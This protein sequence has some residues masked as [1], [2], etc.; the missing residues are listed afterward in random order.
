MTYPDTSREIFDSL[1]EASSLWLSKTCQ[2]DLK[3]VKTWSLANGKITALCFRTKDNPKAGL[4]I[5][6]REDKNETTYRV[7]LNI[8]PKNPRVPDGSFAVLLSRQE[9]FG[10]IGGVIELFPTVKIDDDIEKFKYNMKEVAQKHG[11][12]YE[13]CSKGLVGAFRLKD[14]EKNLGAEAGFNF[15][16]SDMDA[17]FQNIM[18][19]KE[20]Y[21]KA[22]EIYKSIMLE[23]MHQYE[24]EDPPEK[25]PF[26]QKHLQY[27]KNEDVGIKLALEQGI[28]MDFFK[29]STF[30]P[31]KY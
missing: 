22:L 21:L 7:G 26:W 18:F 31:V 4:S 23:R 13:T 20:A 27:M 28:P 3:E 9:E 30:P 15:Y 12:N 14:S 29:F 16:R 19:A 10:F 24:V 1:F 5:L 2:T 11:Q 6:K 8:Y 17:T 25:E